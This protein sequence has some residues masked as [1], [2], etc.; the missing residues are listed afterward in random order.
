MKYSQAPILPSCSQTRAVRKQLRV[1]LWVL[2]EEHYFRFFLPFLFVFVVVPGSSY[3]IR[4][5]PI[6]TGD[7]F[8][9]FSFAVFD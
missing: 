3:L 6:Y 2:F 5:S 1:V 8:P 4:A 9:S 7:F